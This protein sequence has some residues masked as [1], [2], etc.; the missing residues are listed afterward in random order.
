VADRRPEAGL[1]GLFP[2]PP[3][4]HRGFPKAGG[5]VSE[6][7]PAAA[8]ETTKAAPQVE[9][10]AQGDPAGTAAPDT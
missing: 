9:A 4:R 6:K 2:A 10:L 5:L 8:V 3:G 1:K 7:R